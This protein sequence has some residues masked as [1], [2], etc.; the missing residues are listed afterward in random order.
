M[1][2]N[3]NYTRETIDNFYLGIKHNPSVEPG[4]SAS[5]FLSVE[6]EDG[7]EYPIFSYAPEGNSFHW[8]DE[9]DVDYCIRVGPSE[10]FGDILGGIL[11][12][13]LVM[14]ETLSYH[15]ILPEEL[16]E[17]EIWLINGIVTSVLRSP[18]SYEVQELVMR[19][20]EDRASKVMREYFKKS[21]EKRAKQRY[22]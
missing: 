14:G 20:V 3:S 22:A 7:V 19:V 12:H 17:Q 1:P 21:E 10:D 16:P 15:S 18:P 4:W 8:T 13:S 2:R 9:K 11:C 6:H 5:Y